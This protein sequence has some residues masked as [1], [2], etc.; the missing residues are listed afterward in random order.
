M[1]G[2][3]CFFIDEEAGKADTDCVYAKLSENG[4]TALALG[5]VDEKDWGSSKHVCDLIYPTGHITNKADP[6]CL[7]LTNSIVSCK[8]IMSVAIAQN[9]GSPDSKDAFAHCTFS[10]KSGN[11]DN[12]QG[13]KFRKHLQT[14]RLDL[15]KNI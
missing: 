12:G 15:D 14:Q 10:G 11:T 7:R 9:A 8:Y 6:K 5:S 4:Y 13:R 2:D 1:G 3:G